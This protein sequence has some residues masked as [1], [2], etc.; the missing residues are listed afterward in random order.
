MIAYVVNLLVETHAANGLL[1]GNASSRSSVTLTD[2]STKIGTLVNG[3]QIRGKAYKLERQ[4][5][6]VS[7]GRYKHHFRYSI[8]DI[9]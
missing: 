6:V 2:L 3:E 8:P 1:K 5:N 9:N 7:L 4:D